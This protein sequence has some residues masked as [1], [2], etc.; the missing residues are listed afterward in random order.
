[1]FETFTLTNGLRVVAEPIPHFR[2]VSVG[3]WVGA[4]SMTELPSENGLSHFLEHMLFKGTE[5]RSARA[6][7]EEMDGIGGQINAFTAKECTCY[8]AKVMDEHLPIAMDVLTDI[9]L[10]A[11]LDAGELE[12][13]RGVI[14]EE[15]AMVEDTPEDI[16]HDLLS[17]AALAGNPLAQPILGSAEGIAAYPREALLQYKQSHYRPDNT[18]L[19]VAGRYDPA[20]LRALAEQHLGHF[21][22]TEKPI[23]PASPR[24]FH[25]TLSR[26][27]KDIEQVHLCIG[28]P[29]VESGSKDLY[30]LS[31]FNNLFGG[32]M[33]SR[34]FQRIREESGMAYT[35]YSYPTA[36][37]ELGLYT[38]YAGTSKPHVLP[39]LQ[40]LREEVALV[41]KDGI[42]KEEFTKAREQ[43]KGGYILGLESASSR[44][45][46]IGRGELLLRRIHSEDEVIE[47]INAVTVEDVMRVA[48]GILDSPNAASV[49]GRDVE[50]IP[51]DALLWRQNG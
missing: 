33:S 13:E 31:V 35:V 18:V 14:L 46:S 10:N 11:T 8:Y 40:M 48:T 51:E 9:L 29:G 21:L 16:V 4:G 17:D 39:V 41:L 36:Y 22:P 7:A 38:L 44:M 37:P 1:M 15:I 34:L 3:L 25:P 20:A 50:D 42:G 43:L 23:L 2:S 47:Q 49:V 27:N 6:I 5:R 24:V 26:K 12:K 45:S 19:S 28:F 32:G 30:P